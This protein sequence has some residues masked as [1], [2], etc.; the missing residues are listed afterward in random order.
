MN[1]IKNELEQLLPLYCHEYE[2]IDTSPY[3]NYK[4]SNDYTKRKEKLIRQQSRIYYPLIKTTGRR[5]VTA[6]IA[7]VLMGAVTVA[8]CPP[9]REL[10]SDFI[11]RNFT[12]HYSVLSKNNT[13]GSDEH[14]DTIETQYMIAVPDEFIQDDTKTFV[15]DT[16]VTHCYYTADKKRTIFFSQYTK[17]EYN[18]LYDNQNAVLIEKEDK[19]GGKYLIH[20]YNDLTTSI[21]WDNGEYIFDINGDLS[22]AEILEIYYS[23]KIVEQ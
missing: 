12:D 13:S 18:T 10:F 15:S 3:V 19:F 23:L 6:V 22:E 9:V 21:V 8:A 20:N 7:V 11:T 16:L 17:N 2:S 14:K 5:I 4:F 1:N